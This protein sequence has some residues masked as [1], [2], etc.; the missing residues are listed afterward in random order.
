MEFIFNV[1]YILI[2][3]VIVLLFGCFLVNKIGFLKCYNIF[4]FVVGGLVVVIIFLV[5]YSFWG[6]SIIISSEL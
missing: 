3:V 1:F 5:V 4:E 2:V 6:Y